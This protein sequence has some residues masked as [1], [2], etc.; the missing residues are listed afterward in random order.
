M[1]LVV[2]RPE[3]FSGRIRGVL[4]R[5]KT[6]RDRA[7][8]FVL[9]SRVR[10]AQ[11]FVNIITIPNR[12]RRERPH[13]FTLIELLVVIAII[14]ILAAMLLPALTRAKLKATQANCLGNDHQLGL[15]FNMYCTD[16]NDKII[17]FNTAGG[18]WNPGAAPWNNTGV[19]AA[20]AQTLVQNFL[21]SS[22]YNPMFPQAPN[23]AIYHCP[24]DL[25]Y[26]NR[27][28]QGWA[29]DSY[30]KTEN[31]GGES[32]SSYWGQ[33]GTYTKISSVKTPVSTFA[34]K[35]DVDNRGYNDG[36]WVVQWSTA[37]SPASPDGGVRHTQS[38]TWVD[39]NPMYHGNVST[40]SFVDGHAE[41]H[42]W[43]DGAQIKEGRAVASGVSAALGSIPG[44][45]RY[46][47]DYNYIYEGFRFPGGP[48][49]SA[50]WVE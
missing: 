27:P 1:T 8:S 25:R 28:G 3:Y 9:S 7:V 29:Y 34:F 13:G 38:F 30:S 11:C 24:G 40:F 17:G 21:G 14:A 6:E 42:K 44:A 47:S 15:A 23:A 37:A 19:N 20:Q 33:G 36:T 4:V 50:G 2:Y 39:P 26:R 43:T 48:G 22:V 12:L 31:V 41:Y 5:L 45:L 10:H 18:F 35:E 49:N 46:G 32:Y 16:N